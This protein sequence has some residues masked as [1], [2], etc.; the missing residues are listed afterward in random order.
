MSVSLTSPVTGAAV[1]GLTSP[2]Y[3]LTSD[4]APNAH[5]KQWA[6]TALGGTQTG[7]DVHSISNPFTITVER[8]ANFR[9][10]GTPN[11]VTGVLGVQARNVF[12]IRFRKG[13]LP[14]SGQSDQISN[15]EIRIPIPA[16]ADSADDASISALFSFM[17]GVLY[18]N[19]DALAQMA[20][21]G[22]V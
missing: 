20:K 3:T 9:G 12:K 21:D 15:S 7:V 10:V 13:M 1:T 4:S 6:V 22:I 17:G 2:T 8:P 18:A 5:S 14:L 19:A 11:P 16:G